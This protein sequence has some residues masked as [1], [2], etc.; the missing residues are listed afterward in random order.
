MHGY[1]IT[2]ALQEAGTKI[3]EI[4]QSAIYPVLKRM[5]R[6]GLV[7]GEWITIKTKRKVHLYSI[8]KRGISVR[9]ARAACYAKVTKAIT[10]L[11]Q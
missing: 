9:A 5:E 4:K 11:V 8:T 6:K 2:K 10:N 7:N 1:Q 3:F